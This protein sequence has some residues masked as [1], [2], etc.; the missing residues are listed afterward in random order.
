MRGNA[1]ELCKLHTVYGANPE[2][3]LTPYCDFFLFTSPEASNKT[4]EITNEQKQ[5]SKKYVPLSPRF[6]VCLRLV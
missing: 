6:F 3:S 2:V 1:V 5:N 4:G